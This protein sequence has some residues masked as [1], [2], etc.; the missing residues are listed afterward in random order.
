MLLQD[1]ELDGVR[2]FRPETVKL[3]TSVQTPPAL[4]TRRGL[5]WDIDSE[6]SRPRGRVFPLGSYGH[7][8]FTGG[9]L[10]ID[11]ASETFWIFLSNRVHPDGAG[12]IYP[13]QRALGTL[14]AE[15]VA[16]YRDQELP[17]AAAPH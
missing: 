4:T 10:W 11:P 8:G 17:A 2:I 3:M 7:T 5:G 13:L 1:G 15:A 14:A 16:P 12:N 6:F 9:C